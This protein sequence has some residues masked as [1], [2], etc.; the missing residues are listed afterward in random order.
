MSI[1][2]DLLGDPVQPKQDFYGFL[3]AYAK[4]MSGQ[5]FGAEEVTIAAVEAGVLP[6]DAMRSTGQS[7]TRAATEGYIKRPEPS[8]PDCWYRR[9]LG[10]GT[11]ARA[12]VGV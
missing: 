9:K 11:Q 5:V 10:N 6:I 3:I 2:F 4:R 7:F 12:W 8:H 1:Q